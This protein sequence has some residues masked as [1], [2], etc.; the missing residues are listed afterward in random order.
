[1]KDIE[2]LKKA[3]VDLQQVL[4][5]EEIFFSKRGQLQTLLSCV[6]QVIDGTIF[7]SEEEMILEIAC[8]VKSQDVLDFEW[9]K[10]IAHALS[11]KLPSQKMMSEEEIYQIIIGCATREME[12]KENMASRILAHALVGRIPEREEKTIFP[13][14]FKCGG[15]GICEACKHYEKYEKPKSAPSSA[16]TREEPRALY[17]CSGCNIHCQALIPEVCDCE[18][19]DCFYVDIAKDYDPPVWSKIAHSAPAHNLS[20]EELVGMINSISRADGRG[21]H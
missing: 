6:Q 11:H 19:T 13:E 3:V 5:N 12:G 14:D 9:T 1:M 8:V 15:C 20:R 21:Y 16:M 7:A 18:P 2:G 10:K 4:D 17:Q